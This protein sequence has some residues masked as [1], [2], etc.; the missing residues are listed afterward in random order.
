M[1]KPDPLGSR[2]AKLLAQ[3]NRIGEAL[4]QSPYLD[5]AKALSLQDRLLELSPQP[6]LEAL[7][8]SLEW[9]NLS[10]AFHTVR[11][12][13]QASYAFARSAELAHDR[14]VREAYRTLT[15]TS[16]FTKFS[17]LDQ[18][19]KSA[20]QANNPAIRLPDDLIRADIERAAA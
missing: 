12:A 15:R 2:I 8:K 17:E 1:T 6:N 20:I 14:A 18:A 9:P 4:R 7:T 16:A 11:L 13:S 10:S 5:L 3:Q 19:F